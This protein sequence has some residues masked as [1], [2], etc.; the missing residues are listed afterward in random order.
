MHLIHN[1]TI[2]ADR[3]LKHRQ[4]KGLVHGHTVSGR[5]RIQTWTERLSNLNHDAVLPLQKV[6]YFQGR[7]LIIMGKILV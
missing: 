5:A 2:T 7:Q 4:V 6:P 1:P 3:E